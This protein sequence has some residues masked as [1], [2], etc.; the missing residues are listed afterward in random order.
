MLTTGDLDSGTVRTGWG[1]S[2]SVHTDGVAVDYRGGSNGWCRSSE[3]SKGQGKKSGD[4]GEEHGDGGNG[5]AAVGEGRP[6]YD[7]DSPLG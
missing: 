2:G 5:T 6:L 1:P 7:S 3:A 4:G